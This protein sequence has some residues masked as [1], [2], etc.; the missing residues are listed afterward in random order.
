MYSSFPA[1]IFSALT[2]GNMKNS[3]VALQKVVVQT[4]CRSLLILGGLVIATSLIGCAAQVEKKRMVSGYSKNGV[5]VTEEVV[6]KDRQFGLF[7]QI[8]N[9][10]FLPATDLPVQEVGIV[11]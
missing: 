8:D 11:P 10:S 2:F 7:Q 6:V 5:L 4:A 3:F 1:G 9:A